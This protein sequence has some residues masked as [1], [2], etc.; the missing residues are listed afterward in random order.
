MKFAHWLESQSNNSKILFGSFFKDGTVTVYINGTRY[1][2]ITDASRHHKWDRELE[3]T[4]R[5]RPRNYQKVAFSFLNE[6]KIMISLGF[7]TQEEPKK[8][9]VPVPEPPTPT[10]SMMPDKPKKPIQRTLF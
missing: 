5:N 10:P 2:Y 4:K 7:A 9:P 6:I 8:E 1:V 3:W